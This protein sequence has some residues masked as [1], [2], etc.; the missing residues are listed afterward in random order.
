MQTT[1]MLTEYRKT[2]NS[3]LGFVFALPVLSNFFDHHTAVLF[4][5]MGDDSAPWKFV[6]MAIVGASVLLPYFLLPQTR[7][8]AVVGIL[9]VLFVISCFTYLKLEST[10]VI[11]IPHPDAPT[12]FVTR[13]SVRNP[14]LKEPYRSMSDY[15]LIE[16]SGQ[17]DGELEHAYTQGSLLVNRNKLFWS[18]VFSLVLLEFMLGSVALAGTTLGGNDPAFSDAQDD[19]QDDQVA[20]PPDGPAAAVEAVEEHGEAAS[21]ER[22][23]AAAGSDAAEEQVAHAEEHGVDQREAQHPV[24]EVVAE[25]G[26]VHP[27][28]QARRGPRFVLGVGGYRS[29][30]QPSV[31]HPI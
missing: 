11:A 10:Y 20:S 14:E 15:D 19:A 27:S 18:Y 13:G 9:F 23:Q 28:E 17:S 6:A 5:P 3:L 24:E 29:G 25:G 16:N 21:A 1:M 7:R 4:P 12:R 30:L 2:V 22:Q 8:S 26:V 31:V